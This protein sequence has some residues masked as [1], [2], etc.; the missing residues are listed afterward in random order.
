MKY[1]N[2]LPEEHK[3]TSTSSPGDKTVN[4]ESNEKQK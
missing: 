1:I 4:L 3:T 2:H